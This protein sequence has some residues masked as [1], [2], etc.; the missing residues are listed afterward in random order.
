MGH[1]DGAL[2]EC[3]RQHRQ[4]EEDNIQNSSRQLSELRN[5]NA[6]LEAAEKD[7]S[8]LRLEL[9]IRSRE[10]DLISRA[11]EAASKQHHDTIERVAKLEAECLQ[12]KAQ[13]RRATDDSC[14]LEFDR[15][16]HIVPSVDIYLM[17]DFLEME[18]LVSLPEDTSES[19]LKDELEA[20]INRTAELEDTL[21]KITEEKVR[22]EIQL[23]ASEDQLK[24]TEVKL[25][26]LTL[27][28]EA[29]QKEVEC[30]RENM[31]KLLDEAEKNLEKVQHEL[32]E[33]NEAKMQLEEDANVKKESISTLEREVEKEMN[34]SRNAVAKCEIL[35]AE[36]SRIKSAELRINQVG[37]QLRLLMSLCLVCSSINI[38][39]NGLCRINKW[40]WLLLNSPSV[41]RRL[42]LL[43]TSSNLLPLWTTS[44]S[45]LIDN[46]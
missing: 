33:T 21:K 45:T 29:A 1:L 22:L 14:G 37:L 30:T 25:T 38:Q 18:K 3:L 40:Q 11:A 19:R 27:A 6:K 13:A 44:C 23:K 2:K 4:Q 35:E 24:H 15:F 5:A 41:K 26:Q 34:V 42:L 31:T 43:V 7:K 10:R 8:I 46:K 17:D 9:E 16:K 39:G 20:M 28:N 32:K 12:L 36:I